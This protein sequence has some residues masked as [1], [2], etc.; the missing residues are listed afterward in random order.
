MCYSVTAFISKA[1]FSLDN[2]IPSQ[3]KGKSESMESLSDALEGCDCINDIYWSIF[4]AKNR[5]VLAI[6]RFYDMLNEY[7]FLTFSYFV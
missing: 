1:N 7:I 2:K 5:G 3:G 4:L 6:L